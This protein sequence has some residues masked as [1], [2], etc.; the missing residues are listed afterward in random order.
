MS[1]RF[2]A[3]YQAVKCADEHAEATGRATGVYL[4]RLGFLVCEI[5]EMHRN[6]AML[7]H[8]ARLHSVKVRP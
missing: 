8:I 7:V 2:H 6:D 4:D 3:R 5:D 1:R